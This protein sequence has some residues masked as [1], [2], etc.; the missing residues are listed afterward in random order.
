M[1]PAAMA[2]MPS[3][4]D[5]FAFENNNFTNEGD[6]DLSW[7]DDM[8]AFPLDSEGNISFATLV[9]QQNDDASSLPLSS[10]VPQSPPSRD[11]PGS[12]SGNS[13]SPGDVPLIYTPSSSILENG[14]VDGSDSDVVSSTS[15]MSS[16]S[17]LDDFVHVGLHGGAS[18]GGQYPMMD[19]QPQRQQNQRSPTIS[20]PIQPSRQFGRSSNE[21]QYQQAQP[22]NAF[23]Q[24]WHTSSYSSSNSNGMSSR[25]GSQFGSYAASGDVTL[26]NNTAN[27]LMSNVGAFDMSNHTSGSSAQYLPIRPFDHAIDLPSPYGHPTPPPQQV[28]S[29]RPQPTPVWKTSNYTHHDSYQNTD[30]PNNNAMGMTPTPQA[31]LSSQYHAYEQY[32]QAMALA[33]MHVSPPCEDPR[34]RTPAAASIPQQQPA[35]QLS[36][37]KAESKP[38]AASNRNTVRPQAEDE[39]AASAAVK[40]LRDRRQSNATKPA[41]PSS[42][43]L[44]VP[45]GVKK[46][47][48]V[49]GEH[50]PEKTRAKTTLL[51]KIGACWR[52]ALQRDPC[53]HGD[54]CTRCTMQSQRGQTYF[55]DCDRSK[56][57][58]FVHDF[59]P[60][61]MTYLFQKQSIEDTVAREV[62]QWNLTNS[63][64]IHLHSGYGPP[65]RWKV[66]EFEPRSDELLSQLQYHTRDHQMASTFNYA[67]PYG[68]LKIDTSDETH[69]ENYLDELLHPDH[70]WDFA[71]CFYE[72]ECQTDPEFFQAGVLDLMCKLYM[73]TTDE[74]LKPLLRLILRL[75]LV[76][77]IMGHTL[78]VSP[79]TLPTLLSNLQH[80]PSPHPA[81]LPE[82]TSPR[83]ANRQLKFFFSI[84]RLTL[85]TKLLK[86]LQQTLHTAGSKSTTFLPSFLVMLG[87]AMSLEEV[88]RTLM[89]QADSKVRRDNADRKEAE[90]EARNA[91]E[92]ID[93]RFRLLVGLFQ[94][95]YR[96][97]KWGVDGDF[98]PGT[99]RVD[100]VGGEFLRELR[101]LVED[102]EDHLHFREE[103]PF[104]A[105]NQCLY[106]TRLTARFLVPFLG[107]PRT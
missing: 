98:G 40:A 67:P 99:P 35:R 24:Q 62:R 11:H 26:Y 42:S 75:Q 59:L 55:F 69:M 91:C 60:P 66:Y 87:F 12:V 28:S 8:T 15:P 32:L 103:V 23:H 57:P 37:E 47:G 65:L 64:D 74:T 9:H 21:H 106:T 45:G 25:H 46:G 92:R 43:K 77:H 51:R 102:R 96:D 31:R 78:A 83:L 80:T 36:H 48:R 5:P 56:L 81:S 39:V 50:L 70:L 18:M 14:G 52:C 38:A 63:I 84:L 2:F 90:T 13:L 34:L 89:L 49:K 16:F 61:S 27:D 88:Q 30:T 93:E 76:T 82:F 104:A 105:E 4:Y 68:L 19:Q 3:G 58:D 33:N 6:L 73:T 94:C 107:L 20:R 71:W 7:F 85:S 79:S 95:K 86:W 44:A 101:M 100:G 72:E 22:P 41:G 54:P 17:Q 29:F 10:A 97:K 53:D 1:A